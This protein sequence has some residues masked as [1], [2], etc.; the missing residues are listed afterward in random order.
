MKPV[1]VKLMD[2]HFHPYFLNA[3]PGLK[4]ALESGEIED[5]P[6]RLLP[7]DIEP[8][9]TYIAERNVGLQLL[10]C[11]SNNRKGGWI[12]PVEVA[13]SYDTGECIKI[14]LLIE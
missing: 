5:V 9:D 2:H 1:L 4:A 11:K 13:Y 10:T 12:N 8:G 3:H 6:F 7:G 14:E